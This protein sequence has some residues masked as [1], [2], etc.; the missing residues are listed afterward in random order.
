MGEDPLRGPDDSPWVRY[1]R[2]RQEVGASPAAGRPP[3]PDL[4]ALLGALEG[5]RALIPRELSEQFTAL[6][7][8]A[9]LTVRVLIDWYLERLEG[10]ERESEVEDIPID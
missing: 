4:A 9:L 7:R 10:G 3:L 1:E 2:L 8:E 5:L 6:V